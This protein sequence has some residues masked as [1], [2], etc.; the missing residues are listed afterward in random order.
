M[1]F[2]D[3]YSFVVKNTITGEKQ[4]IER[5]K[6]LCEFF[7][8]HYTL[9]HLFHRLL[10]KEYV[11]LNDTLYQLCYNSHPKCQ[12]I[13][14][15]LVKD[16]GIEAAALWETCPKEYRHLLHDKNDKN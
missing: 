1:C 4:F 10:K 12:W 11:R 2:C 13:K 5:E 6:T 3:G 8:G 9:P 15:K 14:M 7:E 16:L